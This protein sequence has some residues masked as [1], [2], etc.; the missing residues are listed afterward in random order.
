MIESRR[1]V[2]RKR[3]RSGK[4]QGAKVIKLWAIKC[5][6]STLVQAMNLVVSATEV[7]TVQQEYPTLHRISQC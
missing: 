1:H 6:K 3:K 7:S 4:I 5:G 2:T